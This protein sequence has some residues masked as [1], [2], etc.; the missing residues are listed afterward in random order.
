MMTQLRK[1]LPQ[2]RTLEQLKNHYEVERALASKLKESSHEERKFIYRTM[3]D[4]LFQKV[5]DHPRLTTRESKELTVAANR[6]KL[7]LLEK[8]MDRSKVFV[9]FAPGDCRFALEVCKYFKFV[10]GI[11]ISDQRGHIQNVPDNFKLIIY[12]GYNLALKENSVD[13]VFSDQLI[14]HL[15]PEDTMHHFKLVKRILK[16]EG[17]YVFR[18]PHRFTGPHDISGYFSDEPEGFHLKEWTYRELTSLLKELNYSSWYGIYR[19]KGVHIKMPSFYF[20]GIEKILKTLS[21]QHRV[22]ACRYFL[23][24]IS[25]VAIK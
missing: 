10:Y 9:E 11:D 17:V 8:F 20:M 4:E 23:P 25:M 3:Y 14:E 1:P 2:G 24:G 18:T 15:H 16:K 6:S 21:R 19:V 13:V 12:D 22:Y 7:R 5:P